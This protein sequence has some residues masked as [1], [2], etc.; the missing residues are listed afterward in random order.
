[1][2]Y[3]LEFRYNSTAAGIQNKNLAGLSFR[4]NP[5]YI[6]EGTA[7][8]FWSLE[9]LSVLSFLSNYGAVHTQHN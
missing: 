3:V 1:M 5:T 8:I 6:Q 9:S 7:L 2:K 4:W